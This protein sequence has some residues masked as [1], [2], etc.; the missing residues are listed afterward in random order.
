MEMGIHKIIAEIANN[1]MRSVLVTSVSVEGHAYRKEGAMML[2]MEGGMTIGCISPGC[3]EVDL[4]AR[5][6]EILATNQSQLVQYD[7]KSEDDALWG[8]A[9]GC[10][11]TVQVLLEPVTDVLLE[12]LLEV[13]RKL[14]QGKEVHLIRTIEN[15]GTQVKYKLVSQANDLTA[16]RMLC[17]DER[18]MFYPQIFSPKPRLVIFGAGNDTAPLVELAQNTGFH[19]VVSDWRA[20]LCTK[21]RFGDVEFVVGFPKKI[22]KHMQLTEKDYVVVMSHHLRWDREFL[23]AV[24]NIPLQ[25][26]GVMGSRTRCNLLLMELEVPKWFHAP[27]GLGIGAE[28]PWEIAVSILA[29]V[30]Q[31][32]QAA[33]AKMRCLDEDD[34]H[35][36]KHRWD[37]FGRG[38]KQPN[39][40]AQA[41][42][43]ALEG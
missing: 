2:M 32:K 7:M 35:E 15:D 41:F 24:V 30:I 36:A 31:V 38:K 33:A 8:E 21:E 25:Y 28:G 27:I 29:E 42:H 34:K 37:L 3:M 12:H 5:T 4:L 6:A 18:A 20:A 43:Q 10:G 23:H 22:I 14:N 11:G 13:K 39:G 17:L 1:P 19:I 16:L 9:I 40:A 26:V